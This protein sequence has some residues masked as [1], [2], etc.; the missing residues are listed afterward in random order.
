MARISTYGASSPAELTDELIGSDKVKATK[1]FTVG[2]ILDLTGVPVGTE[3]TL[4]M[5]GPGTTLID[6]LVTQVAFNAS[7]TAVNV[8]TIPTK[9][10]GVADDP[11][12]IDNFQVEGTLS[13]SEKVAIGTPRQLENQGFD[14]NILG[15]QGKIAFGDNNIFGDPAIPTPITWNVVVGEYGTG[16]TDV[17]QL[18][19]K[20][21]IIF[22]RGSLGTSATMSM[23]ASGFVGI[24]TENMQD[25]LH[26][27][28]TVRSVVAAGSGFA[29][30]TN[31]G[32]ESSACGIR[33][34]N[35]NS[36]LT[37]KDST[38][39]ITTHI[40]SSGFSYFTGGR[41][42]IGTSTPSSTLDVKET[43]TDIAGQ[44]IVGGLIDA[45]DRAFGKLCFANTAAA[46]SQPNKIL[47]SIE[48]RKNGSS[49][50][51]I[52]T[53]GVADGSGSNWEKMR[54]DSY[55]FVGIGTTS[56]QRELDVAGDVRITGTLDLFQGNNN[57]FAGTNAG[58]LS[59][60]TA[61]TNTGFGKNSQ[62]VNISGGANTSM[63]AG[64]LG[65]L[66]T[67]NE[68]TAIGINS[69]L[70]LNGGNRNVAVGADSLSAAT[71]GNGNTAIG[72]NSLGSTT[73][74]FFNTAVGEE[75]L[76]NITTGTTNTG[77]GNKAGKFT[78]DGTTANATGNYSVFIGDSA[79]AQANAQNNQIVIGYNTIGNGTHTA[80]IGN[81]TTTALHVGGNNAG[82]VLKSPDGTAYKIKVT[83]AGALTVTAL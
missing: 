30:M 37:L 6:S 25:K 80:T 51:G 5:F 15:Q 68:N 13:V 48:G 69:M 55:G 79:K 39:A 64:S 78:S 57:S 44:I 42:G 58:N 1:N 75:S 56:P 53:F 29:F 66:V 49:N 41:V 4:S 70:L 16:D 3:N 40:R 52:L 7:K 36:Q 61:G 21:G 24:G 38:E 60:I 31:R 72:H 8:G 26:V 11:F 27:M 77:I 45:D 12:W 74:T 10:G 65:A 32:T 34:D 50:R 76:G 19:G 71:T 47:A 22:T 54:I 17:L 43:T 9:G 81:S 28:G 2:S 20:S 63:G 14:L 83:N 46:N 35:N 59:N 62:L 82:I 33:W 73:T 23:N 67:G 18:H